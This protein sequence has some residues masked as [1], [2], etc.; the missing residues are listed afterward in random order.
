[1]NSIDTTDIRV[2]V[3]SKEISEFR[4]SRML[5]PNDLRETVTL[6][7]PDLWPEGVRVKD[8][9]IYTKPYKAVSKPSTGIDSI[10]IV[11]YIIVVY[12]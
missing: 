2:D 7:Q 6:L 9:V 1:M 12:F 10:S 11:V 8:Y 3:A 5:A 4:S